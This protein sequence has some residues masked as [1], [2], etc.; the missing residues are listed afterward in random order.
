LIKR[1]GEYFQVRERA[2]ALAEGNQRREAVALY[3]NE[4]LPAFHRYKDAG[5]KLFEYNVREGQSR[6][7]AILTVCTVTQFAVAGAGVLIFVTGFL[8]GRSRG[9]VRYAL[10]ECA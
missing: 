3:R 7:H 2:L 4:L 6:G 10:G 9:R 8:A 1:R 5:D